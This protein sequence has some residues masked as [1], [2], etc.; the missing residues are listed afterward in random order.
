MKGQSSQLNKKKIYARFAKK[1]WKEKEMYIIVS[2]QLRW[3]CIKSGKVEN[4]NRV[5]SDRWRYK[6]K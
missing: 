5:W 6:E 2:T 4:M 3:K 1:L